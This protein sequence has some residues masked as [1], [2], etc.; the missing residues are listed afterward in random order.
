MTDSHAIITYDKESELHVRCG[1]F[2]DRDRVPITDNN[3]L[4]NANGYSSKVENSCTTISVTDLKIEKGVSR[5]KVTISGSNLKDRYRSFEIVGVL[6]ND[7]YF[8]FLAITK[9]I[10]VAFAILISSY[11]FINLYHVEAKASFEL[12]WISL[13]AVLLIFYNDPFCYFTYSMPSIEV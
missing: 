13:L 10:A 7:K 6:F 8:I 3:K 2:D 4:T 1:S 12:R 9:Y 5:V 11:S